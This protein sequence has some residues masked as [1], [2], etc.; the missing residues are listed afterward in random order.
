V[1]IRDWR[2]LVVNNR[3]DDIVLIFVTFPSVH[4]LIVL[5]VLIVCVPL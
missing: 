4:P 5:I 3:F 2:A 1:C